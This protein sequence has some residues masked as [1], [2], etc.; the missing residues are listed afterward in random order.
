MYRIFPG[1]GGF[2]AA[3]ILPLSIQPK[4][5]T[6]LAATAHQDSSGNSYVS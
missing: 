1:S 2:S 6:S 5:V 4:E 3:K